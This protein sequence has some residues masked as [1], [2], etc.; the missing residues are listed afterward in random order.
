MVMYRFEIYSRESQGETFHYWRLVASADDCEHVLTR[1]RSLNGRAYAEAEVR[2]LQRGAGRARVED[3]EAGSLCLDVR[4]GTFQPAASVVSSRVAPRAA[5]WQYK[6]C[7]PG[8]H[9]A[10]HH[11]EHETGREGIDHGQDAG[12]PG[13]GIKDQARL[14][15]INTESDNVDEGDRP[16]KASASG[17]QQG[18][19]RASKAK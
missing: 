13:T 19:A 14:A 7:R 15:G 6:P 3:L 4:A 8:F 11:R 5:Q 9:L 10:V 16:A 17:Q 12:S 1:S 2:A 18:R